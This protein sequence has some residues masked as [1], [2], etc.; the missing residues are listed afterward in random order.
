MPDDVI[1]GAAK[2]VTFVRMTVER[3]FREQIA[4]EYPGLKKNK[5][6]WRFLQHL[7][8][9]Q[10][11]DTDTKQLMVPAVLIAA[12]TGKK[13]DNHFSAR[14]FFDKFVADTAIQVD[15]DDHIFSPHTG[16]SKVRRLR[17]IHLPAHIL[18][19]I[20][21]ERNSLGEDRVW[22]DTGAKWMY[23]DTP[24]LREADK[25]LINLD[26]AC[27][28]TANL[29]N[30]LNNAHP[31]RYTAAATSHYGE[32]VEV[33]KTCLDAKNQI[34]MMK[35]IR[36]QPQPFYRSVEKSTR[37]FSSNTSI[38]FLHRSIRKVFTQDWLNADLRS[39]QLAIVAR[40]WDVPEITKYLIDAKSAKRTIWMDLCEHMGLEYTPDNKDKV[41][42]P[43]YAIIFG[44]GDDR[45][46]TGFERSFGDGDESGDKAI[47]RAVYKQFLSHPVIKTLVSARQKQ[48]DLI[49]AAKGGADAFGTSIPLVVT[50]KPEKHFDY[51]NCRSIL[52][53]IAQS[54]ELLLLFPVIEAAI[55]CKDSKRGFAITT[56]LHDGFTFV[57]R[58]KED[59]EPLKKKLKK[60]VSEEAN[61]LGIHTELDFDGD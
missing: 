26:N 43:L 32:A 42:T 20:D 61:R 9:G 31:N 25:K 5:P 41:K 33:A 30:Y 7:I 45:M 2:P 1:V 55:E 19:L 46:I 51:D 8:F 38:L 53:S 23:K 40:V 36:D 21:Q 6:Y 35:V 22:M 16:A 47:G 54:Y 28:Q 48:F 14:K 29:C 27:A 24:V 13:C 10:L 15:I 60:M 39:A 56:W 58:K 59:E 49:R 57:S 34:N 11:N 3:S 37:A 44:A 12:I 4:L 18:E 17:A 50:R 52:A